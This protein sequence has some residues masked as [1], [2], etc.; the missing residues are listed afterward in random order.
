[1]IMYGPRVKSTATILITRTWD[2]IQVM[3]GHLRLKLWLPRMLPLE[4]SDSM[5]SKSQA[6]EW[7][8][9]KFSLRMTV[10]RQLQTP[11]VL[12]LKKVLLLL[13]AVDNTSTHQLTIMMMR[14]SMLDNTE[15]DSTTAHAT[16]LPSWPSKCRTTKTSLP[17]ENGTQRRRWCHTDRQQMVTRTLPVETQSAAAFAC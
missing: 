16:L 5:V 17:S 9:N 4:N 10:N 6:L 15:S 8:K 12:W 13:Y 14:V 2:K 7:T 3:I 1:M 11:K